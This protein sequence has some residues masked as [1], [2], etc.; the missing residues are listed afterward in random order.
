M[1][2]HG[3]RYGTRLMSWE[4]E[5][6]FPL[7]DPGRVLELLDELGACRGEPLEQRDRYFNHP[8]RDF[9]ETDEALRIRSVAGRH[10][11]TYKG[12]KVDP[13]TK[14]R[15]E[16]EIPFGSDP[17]DDRRFAEMLTLLGFREVRT[18]EKR[19][20]PYH[21]D[22]ED[23][24]LEIA[25]DEV[26]GLGTFLEIETTAEESTR[27]AARDSVLRLATHLGLSNS[28]RRSYLC[29]LLEEARSTTAR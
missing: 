20:V 16:I 29:L 13:Q 10:W 17:A 9:A 3:P 28:E 14:T 22:W 8:A 6:K 4:V 5:L 15:R 7:A 1:A 18:V 19:R 24:P 12:P 27:D 11:V 26:T 21:L 2:I 23:R 25:L